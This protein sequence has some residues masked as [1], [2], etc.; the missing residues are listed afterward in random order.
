LCFPIE[1]T[2]GCND[3]AACNFNPIAQDHDG[4][5]IY[6]CANPNCPGD[7][8]H[9]G[10]LGANDILAVLSEYGCNTDCSK[11]I[12]GDGAVTANDI[13]AVL[14]LYGSMCSE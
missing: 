14:A 9:D 12:T 4:S 10:L 2:F 5:C 1:G 13:L 11:D 7:F 8:N 6:D 3:P